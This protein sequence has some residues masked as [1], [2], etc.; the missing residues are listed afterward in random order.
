MKLLQPLDLSDVIDSLAHHDLFTLAAILQHGSL[1]PREHAVVFQ[2]RLEESQAQ[3]DRLLGR[4][5]VE[6]D[7]GRLGFRVRPNAGQ[8][9]KEALYRRNLL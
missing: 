6:P 1:T 3:I 2:R 9:V 8:L 5:I 4:E 7:P